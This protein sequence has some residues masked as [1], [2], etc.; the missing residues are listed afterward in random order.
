MVLP[1]LPIKCY[2]LICP[3]KFRLVIHVLLILLKDI[4]KIKKYKKYIYIIKILLTCIRQKQLFK[5]CFLV[6]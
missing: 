1:L 3:D 5:S 6:A 4:Y 2:C